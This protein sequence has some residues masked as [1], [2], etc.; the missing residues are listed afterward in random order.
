MVKDKVNSRAR[1]K[2][3][4][5]NRQP[6]SGRSAGGGLRIGEMERDAVIAHG[7]LQFLK[8]S[9]MERSDKYEMYL[10]ENSGQIAVANPSKNRYVCPN[11]DGPLEF[12]SDTLELESLNSKKTDIVKVEVPYNVKMM[13]QECEAMGIS[14]RLVVRGKAE[15]EEMV[16]RKPTRF[17]P[18]IKQ[19]V[20]A[21]TKTKTEKK[22]KRKAPAPLP[23]SGD[24]PGEGFQAV[25]YSRYRVGDEVIVVKKGFHYDDL[26][27]VV[28]GIIGSGA[29]KKYEL[30]VVEVDKT[31]QGRTGALFQL[32]E[33][34]LRPYGVGGGGYA[35]MSPKSP[36]YKPSSP[37]SPGR[38]GYGPYS[39]HS[40]K[41]PPLPADFQPHSPPPPG[42]GYGYGPYSPHSPKSPPLPADF[43]PD[44]P[45]ELETDKFHIGQLVTINTEVYLDDDI[46]VQNV[47]AEVVGKLEGDD[48]KLRI[49]EEGYPAEE[50]TIGGR[51][52]EPFEPKTPELPP[53]SP[54]VAPLVV[55]T[56][57]VT[58]SDID[59]HEEVWQNVLTRTYTEEELRRM[60]TLA[61]SY[62]LDELK[63]LGIDKNLY[64]IVDDEDFDR[65]LLFKVIPEE[66]DRVE[67]GRYYTPIHLAGF[68][69][70]AGLEVGNVYKLVDYNQMSIEV[71]SP[72]YLPGDPSPLYSPR[73]PDGPL[74]EGKGKQV[75]PSV[76]T[77]SQSNIEAAGAPEAPYSPKSPEEEPEPESNKK[78]A[79]YNIK[80]V[81]P[82][83]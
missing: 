52:L 12:N 31:G 36:G 53:S 81:K 19:K 7:A 34:H 21:K 75:E 65:S 60:S 17:V 47:I 43:Q 33:Y 42:E 78:L 70:D 48:Y 80:F 54:K 32:I 14:M 16:I 49:A 79:K 23:L 2:M 38:Y 45:K 57:G 74:K 61:Q 64:V 66:D 55:E 51:Y 50:L 69:L 35:P 27:C 44:S 68:N 4:M 3:T 83:K 10:S 1:G 72:T 62:N 73:G 6:P 46:L 76:F 30:K 13:S 39:P 5:K 24:K 67:T 58:R 56:T 9:T 82:K 59:R 11:V 28:V 8:E 18:Q 77:F 71:Y 29:D 15:P 37:R 22:S 20:E 40:P 25:E 63:K 41:S 26:L